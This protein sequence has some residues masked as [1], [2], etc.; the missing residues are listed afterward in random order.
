MNED[1]LTESIK[2]VGP[3]H[4]IIELHDN[5]TTVTPYPDKS[6]ARLESVTDSE[7]IVRYG[8]LTRKQ[9]EGV[10]FLDS[11][12]NFFRVIKRVFPN[13]LEG[14]RILDC[15]CNAGGYCFWAK[16]FGADTAFGFDVRKHWI[17]QANFVQQNRTKYPVD[18]IQFKVT[19]LYEIDQLQLPKVDVTIFKGIFYHLPL[20]I[21]GIQLAADLTTDLFWFNS[22]YSTEVHDGLL[23]PV[24]EDT[25]EVMSGVHKLSWLPTGP[26]VIARILM[27]MGF[28]DIRVIYANQKN[29]RRGR[30]EL[31]ARRKKGGLAAIDHYAMRFDSQFRLVIQKIPV[32]KI[33]VSGTSRLDLE[34]LHAAQGFG[35]ATGGYADAGSA[36]QTDTE[37]FGIT[38]V[39][40]SNEARQSCVQEADGSVLLYSEDESQT[41]ELAEFAENSRKR[42]LEMD[43]NAEMI[44]RGIS[45]FTYHKVNIAYIDTSNLAEEHAPFVIDSL[46]KILDNQSSILSSEQ[47][48]LSVQ[49][50]HSKNESTKDQ[51]LRTTQ[52]D[53]EFAVAWQA[54]RHR[55]FGD[56]AQHKSVF[57]FSSRAIS[58]GA[59]AHDKHQQNEVLKTSDI[60]IFRDLLDK[61][62]FPIEFLKHAMECAN[63]VFWFGGEIADGEPDGF[64]KPVFPDESSDLKTPEPIWKATGAKAIVLALYWMGFKDVR[65]LKPND[66]FGVPQNRIEIIAAREPLYLKKLHPYSARFNIKGEVIRPVNKD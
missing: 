31:I 11:R 53:F 9:N 16:E 12:P 47:S 20:P 57:D 32:K 51:S 7:E 27:S 25:K 52:T 45:W 38:E 29:A 6:R 43:V 17:D 5:F 34:I 56:A 58:P 3:W 48:R 15:A 46:K 49:Q 40:S 4:Q 60:V 24:F 35:L 30:L 42:Y 66:T 55:L 39:Q 54:I 59:P 2:R 44:D 63:E 26:L 21:R 41:L 37:K 18:G 36:S 65:I 23:Q 64:L 19:D 61:T 28:E 33:I 62:F 50:N 22:T 8:G 14:K 1:E 13:G 10:A